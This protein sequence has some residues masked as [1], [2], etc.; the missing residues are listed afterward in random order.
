MLLLWPCLLLLG[1]SGTRREDLLGSVS[2]LN[3]DGD[4]EA[5]GAHTGPV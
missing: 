1:W 3:C 2:V 4:K 5:D